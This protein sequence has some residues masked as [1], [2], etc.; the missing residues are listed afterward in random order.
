M[1]FDILVEQHLK[2]LSEAGVSR[3]SKYSN[4]HI[5]ADRLLEKLEAGD[6]DILITSW[7]NNK[8]YGNVSEENIKEVITK[9]VD[10][11]KT[12]E[13]SSFEDLKDTIESIADGIYSDKGF[14]RQS[15]VHRLTN[16]IAGLVMH[17]EYDLVS[18]L[19]PKQE[20]QEEDALTGLTEVENA[21]VDYIE[22][23]EEPVTLDILNK[24]FS[25][26][27]SIVETLA[28]KGIVAVNPQ[29]IITVVSRAFEGEL[30]SKENPLDADEDV[31]S[32]FSR[33]MG[34][35]NEDDFDLDRAYQDP[36]SV[37]S[38]KRWAD[39]GRR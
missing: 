1:K 36:S 22:H 21:V 38:I 30:K 19:P 35:S 23:S 6:F 32:S 39:S 17:K 15:F 8:K 31:R 11:I 7:A 26:A 37:S 14:R 4:I 24:H 28:E 18:V 13:I 16:S 34:R 27:D 29:G 5:N 9:L 3:T 2:I 12:Y 25:G 33:T 10:D 20:G